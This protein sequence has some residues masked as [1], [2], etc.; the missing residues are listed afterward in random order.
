MS[1]FLNLLVYGLADG[2]ILALAILPLGA[3]YWWG[4][5]LPFRPVFAAARTVLIILGWERLTR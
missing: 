3:I 1:T 5:A 2:A 4:F